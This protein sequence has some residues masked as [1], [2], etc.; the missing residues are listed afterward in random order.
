MFMAR[1]LVFRLLVLVSFFNP[2]SLRGVDATIYTGIQNP[3]K[4]TV[5]N[6]L[7]DTN[8]GAV[9]GARISVG[10]VIGFEQNFGYSP[11]FLEGGDHAFNTQS[12]L[13]LGFP[14]GHITPYGTVGAGL[15]VTGGKALFD[16]QNLGV[17]FTVNY[18]GGIK[19]YNL[20]GP[21]GFRVDAR[22]Y[23]VPNVFN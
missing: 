19:F 23:S 9:V 5:G 15:I 6:V 21:I 22:G 1:T 7:Q 4:L 12:N 10:K 18:G 8:L 14:F 20:A 11:N 13:V 3:G 16:V 2:I 17:K